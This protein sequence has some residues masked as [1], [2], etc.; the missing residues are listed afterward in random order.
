TPYDKEDSGASADLDA[1]KDSPTIRH[2]R[3]TKD[4][5]DKTP[6]TTEESDL[7]GADDAIRVVSVV[8][9]NGEF[10]HGKPVS[11]QV[12]LRY[13][14]VSTS[15]AQIE[16]DFPEFQ[17]QTGGCKGPGYVSFDEENRLT[18]SRGEERVV[19]PAVWH[20]DDPDLSPNPKEHGLSGLGQGFVSV[21]A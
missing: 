14:L 12:A 17:K 10:R 2:D 20:A 6:P 4:T 7:P 8:P 5:P 3:K 1:N 11:F 16:V 13:R 21:R 15:S 18:V 9:R 19:V